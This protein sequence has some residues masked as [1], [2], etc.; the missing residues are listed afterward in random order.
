MGIMTGAAGSGLVCQTAKCEVKLERL[1]ANQQ[2]DCSSKFKR[3]HE[4]DLRPPV[5][6]KVKIN[7]NLKAISSSAGPQP[8]FSQ[9]LA[10]VQANSTAPR[11]GVPAPVRKTLP[12]YVPLP[13]PER[14]DPS[15]DSVQLKEAIEKLGFD[16]KGKISTSLLNEDDTFESIPQPPKRPNVPLTPEELLPPTPCVYVSDD[17]EAMSPQLLDVCLKR[18]IVLV[19]N[20]AQACRMDLGLYSTKTLVETHPNHPVEIR[21]QME[22]TSDENWSPNMEADVWYCTSSRSHTTIA[23]YAEYQSEGIRDYIE[24]TVS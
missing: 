12:T 1:S 5:K 13:L 3:P 16:P 21:S 11:G 20:L 9:P 15:L 14:F 17:S 6:L 22:Q 18:P 4:D 2:Q 7:G 19:R 8:T 23:K 10:Q 24:K